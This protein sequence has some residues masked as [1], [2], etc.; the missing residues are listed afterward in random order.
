MERE[1]ITTLPYEQ[2]NFK[3]VSNHYDIHLNGT[4]MYNGEL[5]DFET[6]EQDYNNEKELTTR[7]YKLDFNGKIKRLWEQWVFE[8]CVGFHW[9]YDNGE[10]G[11]SFSYRRPKWLYKLLFSWY[12]KSR[13]R[14]TTS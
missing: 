4:C 13:R 3:F 9:S 5:C 11:K 7:I 12:Y 1:L 2:V 6:D 8:Q 10:K 14:C